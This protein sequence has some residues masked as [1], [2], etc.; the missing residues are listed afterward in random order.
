MKTRAIH[1][2]FLHF[3]GVMGILLQ[4]YL[5]LGGCSTPATPDQSTNSPGQPLYSAKCGSCHRL[6][7]PQDHTAPT[8]RHY[9]DKYGKK[10]TAEQKQLVLDYLTSNAAISQKINSPAK[11]F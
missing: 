8:W 3:V 7:P 10:M 4:P 5:F 11:S 6:L 1:S 9:V 2:G